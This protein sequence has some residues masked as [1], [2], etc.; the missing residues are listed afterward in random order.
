MSWIGSVHHQCPMETTSSQGPK[1]N[2]KYKY[3]ININK[4]IQVLTRT[5]IKKNAKL[6]HQHCRISRRQ[7]DFIMKGNVIDAFLF[8]KQKL[9][10]L[11]K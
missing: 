10:E 2:K 1:Y 3:N 9:V 7:K 4:Y 5:P 6:I 11:Q 8:H